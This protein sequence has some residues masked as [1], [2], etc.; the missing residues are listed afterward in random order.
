[1]ALAGPRTP[2]ARPEPAPAEQAQQVVALRVAIP[3]PGHAPLIVDELEAL[4]G[5]LTATYV[6]GSDFAV[7]YD[8]AKVSVDDILSLEVFRAF[9]AKVRP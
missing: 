5:V 4:D 2:T 7:S 6:G 8:P 3:C 9:R 1:R